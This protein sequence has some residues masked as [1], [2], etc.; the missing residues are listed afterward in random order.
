MFDRPFK[1][2]LVL[3]FFISA[4]LLS[5]T[6]LANAKEAQL[7]LKVGNS[8]YKPNQEI[9]VRPGEMILLEAIL[10]NGPKD[11]ILNP[12][13]F[14]KALNINNIKIKS[15]YKN[16]TLISINNGAHK[17]STR[18]TGESTHFKSSTPDATLESF[19]KSK[20]YLYIPKDTYSKL[21]I[22]IEKE[23]KSTLT[24]IEGET[25][26]SKEEVDK[27]KEKFYFVIDY[28]N[29]LTN[30]TDDAFSSN[31]NKNQGKRWYSSSNIIATGQANAQIAWILDD[32]QNNYNRIE[33]KIQRKDYTNINQD[34]SYFESNL[35][36][37]TKRIKDLNDENGYECYIK[38][39]GNPATSL[40]K[41][42]TIL[43]EKSQAYKES[44]KKT[45]DFKTF[46]VEKRY[47]LESNY[48]A[49]VAKLVIK[50]FISYWTTLPSNPVEFVQ[51]P[52]ELKQL[53]ED[54]KRDCG[55]MKSQLASYK[56]TTLMINT[57]DELMNVYIARRKEIIQE[58]AIIYD[59]KELKKINNQ[60]DKAIKGG[61]SA[62]ITYISEN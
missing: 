50:N 34:L 45:V 14:R 48:T 54:S 21:Y 20:S 53:V 23:E 33:K 13:K 60:L 62:Y 56:L 51:L 15:N 5:F 49:N 17:I 38:L 27:D 42:I 28:E 24:Y 61:Q 39:I 8:K 3:M 40:M 35:P 6:P 37:L 52:F 19:S 36:Y 7:L 29:E 11:F 1:D 10:L 58:L 59:Y 57:A 55:F 43:E 12:E 31:S 18:L 22:T 44:F 26:T 25:I 41:Q 16:H 47:E 9:H 30:Y 32:I 4:L 46:A 2:L